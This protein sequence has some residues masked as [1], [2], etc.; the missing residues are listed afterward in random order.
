MRIPMFSLA[1]WSFMKPC[2][3]RNVLFQMTMNNNP[4]G[5][6]KARKIICEDE[7]FNNDIYTNNIIE[8]NYNCEHIIPQSIFLKKDPYK[9][10][11]H[12]LFRTNEKINNF[13]SN[14]VFREYSS[15][16]DEM[17]EMSTIGC[18][19]TAV[20]WENNDI[21][22]IKEPKRKKVVPAPWSRGRIARSI[23]YFHIR[24]PELNEELENLLP[25][26]LMLKW[27]YQDPIKKSE[28]LR[29]N[30][31][32]EIQNNINPFIADKDLMK[33]CFKDKIT[34]DLSKY[35]SF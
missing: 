24:Y 25:Y 14:Y 21:C 23:G 5:Y 1:L 7:I 19:G 17:S 31:I 35:E 13:R 27:N 32:Y 26:N 33:Y 11:M 18:N 6:N 22:I 34:I 16:V 15:L 30:K 8:K 2:M 29:N 9:S 28:V 3:I 4:V 12:A 10:D 20:N